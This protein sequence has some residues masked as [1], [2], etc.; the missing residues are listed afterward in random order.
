VTPCSDERTDLSKDPKVFRLWAPQRKALEEGED[1][2]LELGR[3]GDFEIEDTV[4]STSDR[5]SVEGF[6]QKLWGFRAKL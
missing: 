1:P 4:T 5:A 2:R 3:L 6:A